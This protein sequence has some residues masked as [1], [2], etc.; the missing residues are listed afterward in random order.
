MLSRPVHSW[1]NLVRA[2]DAELAQPEIEGIPIGSTLTDLLVIEFINGG[3]RWG[4]IQ[5]CLDRLRWLRR[6]FRKSCQ[7]EEATRLQ[8]GR[9]LVT[10]RL[11]TARIDDLILPVLHALSPNRCTVLYKDPNTL[12]RMPSKVEAISWMRA[13]SHDR[14]RWLP[15]SVAVGRSGVLPSNRCAIRSHCRAARW[16]A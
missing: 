5:R 12:K 8:P 9:I 4:T 14:S 11:S 2:F 7:S 13:V 15:P 16:S 1:E 6:Y 10:W 3:G